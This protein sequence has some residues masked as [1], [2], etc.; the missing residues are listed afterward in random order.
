MR[1]VPGRLEYPG[2]RRL[3]APCASEPALWGVAEPCPRHLLV[4]EKSRPGWCSGG[5]FNMSRTLSRGTRRPGPIFRLDLVA[6]LYGQPPGLTAESRVCPTP[7][8]QFN[9]RPWRLRA[10]HSVATAGALVILRVC[11]RACRRRRRD[12]KRAGMG[13][14]GLGRGGRGNDVLWVARPGARRPPPCSRAPSTS[15]RA[16]GRRRSWP[17]RPSCPP[18][19]A[20]SCGRPACATPWRRAS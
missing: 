10:G 15:T 9:I 7:V 6:F 16:R 11:C 18:R 4:H 12:V 20:P 8:L 1:C 14:N 17:P 13:P 2:T 5:F 3:P 19:R